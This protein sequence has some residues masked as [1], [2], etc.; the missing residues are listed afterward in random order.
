MPT[1]RQFIK[2]ITVCAPAAMLSSATGATSSETE[3]K[4]QSLNTDTCRMPAQDVPVIGRYDVIVCGGGPSGT[5]AALA[6]KRT[7]LTV[8]VIESQGQLGGTGVSGMVSEWLG[9]DNGGI[10]HEFA[11]E[12][13]EQGIARQSDWGPAFDPFAM[14]P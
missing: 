7:G 9:G 3:T 13:I 11:T 2:T 5:A 4:S 8:L 6:A 12:T 10:F 14:A 1:R